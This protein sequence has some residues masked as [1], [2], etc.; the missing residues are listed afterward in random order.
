MKQKRIFDAL[1]GVDPALVARSERPRKRWAWPVAAG[2]LAACAALLAAVWLPRPEQPKEPAGKPIQVLSFTGGEI[3]ALRLHSIEYGPEGHSS[4]GFAIYVNEEVYT[5]FEENGV[6]TIRPISTLPEEFPPID[7]T[8]SRRINCTKEEAMEALTQELAETYARVSEPEETESTLF[9]TAGDG[10]TWDAA[11][12]EVLCVDD[13]WGGSFVLTARYFTE[14]AEGHGARFHDMMD[15]FHVV[16][17][18]FTTSP[19]WVGNLQAAADQLMKAIFADR[20][21]DAA[22]LLAE[23]A[24][25][26]GYGRDVSGD[27]SVAAIDYAPD[28]DQAPTSAMVSVKHRTSPEEG[29]NYLTMEL[30]CTGGQWQLTWA[31]IEK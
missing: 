22:N 28:N 15:T 10:D 7:L 30:T 25:V 4:I 20:P 27:V 11:Q 14:A 19:A 13:G 6:Y 18:G 8:I 21:E 9:R 26:D 24:V 29:Y 23:N 17:E 5:T 3:G 1:G 2:A 31:G 16:Y 12:A